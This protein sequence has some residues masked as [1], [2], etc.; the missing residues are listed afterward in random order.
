MYAN[1]GYQPDQVR[2]PPKTVLSFLLMNSMLYVYK[3]K[4][5]VFSKHNLVP[6]VAKHPVCTCAWRSTDAMF[7]P[8]CDSVLAST[9]EVILVI[10]G[11]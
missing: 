11:L 5:D 9:E 2:E 7:L 4:T 10:S 8:S 3:L 1:K 6:F